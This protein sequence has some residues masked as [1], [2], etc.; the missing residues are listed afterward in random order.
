MSNVSRIKDTPPE[1][2]VNISGQGMDRRIERRRPPTRFLGYG[3]AGS[4][5]RYGTDSERQRTLILSERPGFDP[6]DDPQ[7][8]RGIKLQTLVIDS[9]DR[10][11]PGAPVPGS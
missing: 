3:I 2:G 7:D 5:I 6:G 1:Q 10:R 11:R 8:P 4:N 9:L